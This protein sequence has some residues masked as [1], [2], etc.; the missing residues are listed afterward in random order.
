MEVKG[1]DGGAL[2]GGGHRSGSVAGRDGGALGGPDTPGSVAGRAGG[3]L[4]GSTFTPD[5]ERGTA[6]DG[7]QPNSKT[8]QGEHLDS[9]LHG[10]THR[11]HAA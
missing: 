10:A 3:T 9:Q 1:R 8:A 4:G 5:A 7:A 6:H 2:G 11:T